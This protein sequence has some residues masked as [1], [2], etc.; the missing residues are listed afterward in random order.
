MLLFFILPY[1]LKELDIAEVCRWRD[2]ASVQQLLAWEAAR[3][4]RS[5]GG[6]I[7]GRGQG[8]GRGRGDGGRRMTEDR[9]LLEDM[10]GGGERDSHPSSP[11]PTRQRRS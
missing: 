11:L 3:V 7:S 6:G 2:G 8:G 4:R 9:G 5:M 1:F 10:M